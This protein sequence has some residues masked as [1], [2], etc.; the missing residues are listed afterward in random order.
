MGE[1]RDDFTKYPRTPHLFG[2]RGTMRQT[3]KCWIDL[4]ADYGARVELVYVEPP[5]PVIYGQNE[6]R[7]NPVPKQVIQRLVEKL[8]PP[9]WAE[10][11]ALRLVA[12]TPEA[13][14]AGEAVE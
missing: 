3:R 6:R 1:S 10:G 14:V 12:G 2:T 8:E 4:F 11:H 9:V 13:M 5:L 7:C